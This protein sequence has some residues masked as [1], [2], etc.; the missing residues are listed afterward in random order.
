MIYPTAVRVKVQTM[1]SSREDLARWVADGWFQSAEHS[2]EAR[3]EGG[4]AE[5][6][7]G[8]KHVTRELRSHASRPPVVPPWTEWASQA[9][10]E[11]V[12][13]Y[14]DASE[15][16]FD[17]QQRQGAGVGLVVRIEEEWWSL[18]IPLPA[19]QRSSTIPRGRQ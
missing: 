5:L 12:A 1:S 19:G 16:E 18:A 8:I 11:K 13:I 6:G 7:L 4:L 10:G 15:F 3:L 2:T 17:D 14:V 9:R